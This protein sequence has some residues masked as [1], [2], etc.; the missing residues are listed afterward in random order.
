MKG[1]RP[2]PLAD[3]GAAR[4]IRELGS[5][6]DG[7]AA[8]TEPDAA[9]ASIAWSCSHAAC[10]TAEYSSGSPRIYILLNDGHGNFKRRLDYLVGSRF[11]KDVKLGDV[12][13]DGDLDIVTA[14][15]ENSSISVLIVVRSI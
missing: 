5:A 12:D 15:D 3:G 14:S 6:A 13:G 8:G 10:S 2:R 4:R 7:Q 9:R 11:I 1:R